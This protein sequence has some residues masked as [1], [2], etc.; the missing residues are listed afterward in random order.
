MHDTVMNREVT[1][2]LVTHADLVYHLAAAVGVHLIIEQPVRTIETNIACTEIVLEECAKKKTPVLLASTSEVY[3]KL[4]RDKFREDD[5][6]VLGP[7][8][9]SRWCYASSKIIDEFLAQAA[10]LDLQRAEA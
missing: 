8:S 10:D 7:T 3:G 5:D 1:A 4:S 2:E 9:R 6:L